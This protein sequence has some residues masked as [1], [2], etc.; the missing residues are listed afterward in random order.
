MTVRAW[1]FGRCPTRSV[2]LPSYFIWYRVVRDD[3][4]TEIVIRSM[5]SRLACRSGVVGKLLKKRDEAGLWMEL[6]AEVSDAEPFERLLGQ[7]VD[8][9]DVEMFIDGRR[10]TEC[11]IAS[12]ALPAAC[13]STLNPEP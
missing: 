3:H 7:A 1:H 6:Y 11:F 5:M 8:E 13:A 2:D 9:F 4:D 12:E 10:C